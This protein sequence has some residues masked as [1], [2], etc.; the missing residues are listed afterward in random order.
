MLL[1][2]EIKAKHVYKSKFHSIFCQYLIIDMYEEQKM[3]LTIS[4]LIIYSKHKCRN[5]STYFFLL[6]IFPNVL[7]IY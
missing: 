1:V 2:E 4:E 5:I 3:N 7:Q 6:K